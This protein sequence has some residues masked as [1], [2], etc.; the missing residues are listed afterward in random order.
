MRKKLSLWL[1]LLLIICMACCGCKK[2]EKKIEQIKI[3]KYE[4]L[5][6]WDASLFEQFGLEQLDAPY[7]AYH[8]T[9]EKGETYLIGE[10][11][12][13]EEDTFKYFFL[14][15]YD[16][17][18]SESKKLEDLLVHKDGV[19]TYDNEYKV[20]LT[21]KQKIDIEMNNKEVKDKYAKLHIEYD[22]DENKCIIK[23]QFIDKLSNK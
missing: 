6:E 1:V 17:L 13:D 12:T 19:Y 21:K 22:K 9:M 8:A 7:K 11:Y 20:P 3:E 10:F 23:F 4:F 14:R 5:N 15:V 18:W 2:K 16:Q